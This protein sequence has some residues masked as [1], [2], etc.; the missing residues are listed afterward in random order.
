MSIYFAYV[1]VLL[2]DKCRCSVYVWIYL[3]TKL[4]YELIHDVTIT[5]RASSVPDA[6]T[7]HRRIRG[8]NARLVVD[9]STILVDPL[10]ST[11]ATTVLINLQ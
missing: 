4:T 1:T 3:R 11:C 5:L 9:G 8:P 6:T 10:T 2:I 7:S